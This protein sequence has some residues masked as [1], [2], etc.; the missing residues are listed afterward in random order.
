MSREMDACVCFFFF[1]IRT[2]HFII[3]ENIALNAI[4]KEDNIV[5]LFL[6]LLNCP[7]AYIFPALPSF[8]HLR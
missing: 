2:G 4:A 5:H 7:A 1:L 6:S 3:Q 8:A